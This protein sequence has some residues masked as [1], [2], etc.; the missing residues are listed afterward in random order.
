MAEDK[1]TKTIDLRNYRNKWGSK[2]E[3]NTVTEVRDRF[4]AMADARKSSCPYAS[5]P[6]GVKP[7]GSREGTGTGSD[8][9][10]R[11]NEDMKLWSMWHE[12]IQGRTNLKS[13]ISFAPIE[14]AMAEFQDNQVKATL[15][16]REE[17]D[18]NKSI[19]FEK[20]LD[21]LHY[22]A[23]FQKVNNETFKSTLIFGSGFSHVTWIRKSR[24]V[25]IILSGKDTEK[26]LKDEKK[27]KDVKEKLKSGKPVTEK[28]EIVEYDDVALV[29]V[30]IF[31]FYI[32]PDARCM[33]GPVYEAVDCV[34][35]TTPS[36]EQF[37]AEFEGSNDPWIL[38]D[39]IDKVQP[40][41][42]AQS[43]Y[44]DSQ[45]F[46]EAPSD[47]GKA[48]KVEL[49]RYYNKQTDKFCI[50]AND[51]L[52]REGP[53]PYNHKQ[54]PFV[55]HKLVD[56]PDQFYGVGICTLLE[57]NQ[58]EEET[59]K[60]ISIDQMKLGTN[61][62]I[63]VNSQVFPDID[64]QWETTEPGQK[65][66]VDGDVGPGS[67]RVLEMPGVKFDYFQMRNVFDQ[68][69]TKISGINPI[70]SAYPRSNT[71]VRT[72]MLVLESGLK[73]VKKY[74]KNWANGY[75]D[76]IRQMIMLIKQFYPDMY[77]EEFMD[78]KMEQKYK[79]FRS[80]VTR[81][82]KLSD[83]GEGKIKV[84]KKDGKY[85]FEVKGEYLDLTGDLDVEIDIDTLLP[86]SRT[87]KMQKIEAAFAQLIPVAA[88]PMLRNAPG[89]AT[90]IQEYIKTH[91]LPSSV[92]QDFQEENSEWDV[93]IAEAQNKEMMTQDVPGVPGEANNHK[94][95]HLEMLIGLTSEMNGAMQ[96]QMQMQQQQPPEMDEMG[97]PI[98]PQMPPQMEQANMILERLKAHLATDD[99]DKTGGKMAPSGPQAGPS[100]PQA[101]QGG[102]PPAPQQG[103][104]GGPVNASAPMD[105][106]PQMG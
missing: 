36:L 9:R 85:Y 67:I 74:V 61:P 60:N 49:L 34:W 48:N 32:D 99:M 17:E 72:N 41:Y 76:A 24:E 35:R 57:S 25:E 101:P 29:P 33:R 63:L 50:V 88:N 55:L 4:N 22:T 39:N 106:M 65:I 87:V 79:R 3:Y 56:F 1:I 45:R 97:N 52:V 37:K 104:E 62:P 38:K 13:P 53:L 77:T 15:T 6:S 84:E 12:Y 68:D 83:D 66:N 82:E 16:A 93:E 18:E 98:P 89:V 81:N 91:A 7:S 40:A 100:G 103:G 20:I 96:Q 26:M 86:M 44:S 47:I 23:G 10:V 11:W 21:H 46:F 102:Q 28:R 64:Q 73:H 54:L 42:Q 80:I 2:K 95:K 71:A 31:E 69:A 92:G 5:P 105:S 27:K 14:A 8:W 70:M 58:A 90:L 78:E 59:L 75:T 51:V 43:D 19:V 30:S 94:M